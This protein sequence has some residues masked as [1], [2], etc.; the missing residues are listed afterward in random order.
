MTRERVSTLLLTLALA[1]ALLVPIVGGSL[2]DGYSHIES[3]ISELGAVGTQWGSLVSLGGFLTTGVLVILFLFAA[4]PTIKVSGRAKLGYALL[5]FIGLSYVG[6]AFS[7]C[8][9]GC[10]AQGSLRQ[11][12][13][14]TLGIFEYVLGGIGLLLIA[15]G[16]FSAGTKSSIKP[17]L[18]VAGVL[19][20]ASFLAMA[21]PELTQWRGLFQRIA[22]ILLFGSLFQLYRARVLE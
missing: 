10:P 2:V 18:F 16:H 3:Y 9:V 19:V 5:Y 1:M 12:I 13:H 21:T 8:D 22:E 4:A 14:N 17:T 7:P 11:G 6:A 15:S 20:I